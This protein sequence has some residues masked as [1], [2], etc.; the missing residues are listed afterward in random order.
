[1]HSPVHPAIAIA[2]VLAVLAGIRLLRS[3]QT[4]V[5]GNRLGALAMLGAVVAVLLREHVVDLPA[6]IVALVAG[7]TLGSVLALRVTMLRIPQMVALLNGFG[8]LASLLVAAL[9]VLAPQPETTF[10]NTAASGLAMMIG[11]ATFSGSMVAAGK[12][13][14]KIRQQPVF[15][16]GHRSLCGLLLA[17][18]TTL[19][20][21]GPFA[22]AGRLQ[23]AMGVAVLAAL[24][25]GVLF[26]IR[27][28]GADMPVTIELLNALSGLAASICGFA[29]SDG[30][31]IAI[32]AMVGAAGL[33]LTQI[34][35]RAMNRSLSDI[36]TGQTSGGG[37]PKFFPDSPPAQAQASASDTEADPVPED[38]AQQ[39][40][41]RALERIRSAQ[42]VVVA[43]GY[44]MAL[45]Q[46]QGA[47]KR[48]FDALGA[49][50][51]EVQFAIHPVA[52]RMPGHMN[53]LLAEEDIPYD[54]LLEIDDIN[55]R[56]ADIDLVL[57]VGACDV[58]NP[59]AISAEGTPIYGM[60]V[61][62]VH[63]AKSVVVCNLDAKP[64]YSGVDN[65]L[66]GKDNVM[67][68]WGNAA[69]TLDTLVRRL[70][71]AST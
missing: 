47:V 7:A 19:A 20:V 70:T 9:V 62:H 58:V 1:M 13:D 71:E 66:Y 8:G 10:A 29:L 50:G 57:I 17:V 65:P 31:L 59:A 67:T 69:D 39:K 27:I 21:A 41:E 68:L 52:G 5:A 33:I 63:E 24:L 30:L 34:M 14:K 2:V 60:P 22:E 38:T 53:V 56:F 18:M 15:L 55:P 3:P 51:K 61:L 23:A 16:R 28:G 26:S 64:G 42:T 54:R 40:L 46:A 36:L 32:G 48:L 11:G 6:L 45:A 4:A 37:L 12:L 25:F 49:Q 35:C 44:G 43:P